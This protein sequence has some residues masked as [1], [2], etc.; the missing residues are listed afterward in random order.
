MRFQPPCLSPNPTPTPVIT[1]TPT[2]TPGVTPTPG[3]TPTP[4]ITPTPT[5]TPGSSCV[6]PLASLHNWYPGQGSANDVRGS[7]NGTPTGNVTYPAGRVG[8]AFSFPGGE[9]YVT[10]PTI[11]LGQSFSLEFWM[12]PTLGGAPYK[13]LISNDFGSPNFGALYFVADSISY[14]KQG[15]ILG[16]SGTLPLNQ[17]THVALVYDGSVARLYI[18][19]VLD[20]TSGQFSTQFNNQVRFADGMNRDSSLTYQGLLDEV[21]FYDAAI[22]SADVQAIYNA[23][24]FGKCV[25]GGPTPTPTP[26]PNVTPTPGPTPTATP[27]PTP[28]VTPTPSVTPTPPVCLDGGLDPTFNGTGKVAG[29]PGIG[30]AMAIQPDGKFVVVGA[31]AFQSGVNARFGVA[32]YNSN[33]TLDTSFGTNGI[34]STLFSGVGAEARSVAIQADGKIVVAGRVNTLSSP[35][36]N[37]SALARYTSTGTLDTS[38]GNNGTIVT[39]FFSPDS[40]EAR[41]VAIQPDGK[42]ITVGPAS[43]INATN[44][45]IG[46][47]R[48]TTTGSLDSTFGTNG[49]V[50]TALTG[51]PY[52]FFNSILIQ[53]DGKIVTAGRSNPST[54]GN[55]NFNLDDFALFRHLANGAVDTT[56]GTNGQAITNFNSGDEVTKIALQSDGKIVAGGYANYPADTFALARYTSSGVLDVS[57][58]AN[59][60]TTTSFQADDEIN[61]IAIQADGKI[62]AAGYTAGGSGANTRDFA[63]ARYTSSGSLDTIFGSGGKLTTDFFGNFDQAEAIDIQ[64]DGKIV[65]AGFASNAGTFVFALA[66][67]LTPNVSGTCP[68]PTPTPTPNVTPTPGPTPTPGVSPTPTP[69]VTP[70]PTPTPPPSGI[71]ISGRVTTPTGLGLRSAVV[72]LFDAQNVR[73]IATT[74]SFGIY[75]FTDVPVATG[76][77]LTVS[78]KRYRFAPKLMD[79]SQSASNV[80]FVGLE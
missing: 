6:A 27:T 16:S 2:P 30:Y 3:P 54:P 78:S 29:D 53:P 60:K 32:R 56:F 26:T 22:T 69:V 10:L 31:A 18:N 65:A 62:V 40:S 75:S 42:I 1:P 20:R 9:S 8:Q 50:T 70:T 35:I 47:A 36:T 63:L 34:V 33:G 38:F 58:G 67:F 11:N 44:S 52:A 5:P 73:R 68:T 46:L 13:H 71:T 74:S 57:F 4:G 25:A 21:S 76:Y 77:V 37:H 80:D 19:G 17:W 61:A 55:F 23:G 41:G 24:S 28:G 51:V 72:S 64:P 48:Y 14:W 15:S 43:V 39:E 66:R 45:S 12:N 59:G 49:K 7:A 79:I